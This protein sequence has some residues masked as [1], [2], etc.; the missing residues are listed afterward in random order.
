[1]QWVQGNNDQTCNTNLLQVNQFAT[2]NTTA[3]SGQIVSG[4][5]CI[6]V[7][8]SIGLSQPANYTGTI[9]HP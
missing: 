1:M 6:I 4:P 9:S 3:I 2:A 7:Y 5:Y 8:D